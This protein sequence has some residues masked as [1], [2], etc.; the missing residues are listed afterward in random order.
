MK[1]LDVC[2]SQFGEF[3]YHIFNLGQK[4]PKAQLEEVYALNSND[5]Q[6]RLYL[7]FEGDYNELTTQ[8]Y[9]KKN[10]NMTL[11]TEV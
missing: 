4:Y 11:D 1:I 7:I 6:I 5:E 10:L 3:E 2:D 8:E 9:I